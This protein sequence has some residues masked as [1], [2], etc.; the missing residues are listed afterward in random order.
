MSGR[1]LRLRLRCCA[2]ADVGAVRVL[3]VPTGMKTL[4]VLRVGEAEA[5]AES[6]VQAAAH[7]REA[8]G[9]DM[10]V[11]LT[12]GWEFD[13]YEVDEDPPMRDH[14]PA[15]FGDIL[16]QRVALPGRVVAVEEDLTINSDGSVRVDR[17]WAHPADAAERPLPVCPECDG[18]GE[19]HDAF[20]SYPCPKCATVPA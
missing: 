19:V 5:S 9:V 8:T 12:A 15:R 2:G 13:L 20:K 3:K 18:T 11:V 6:T 10:V 1:E 16:L 7:L 4:G 17:G 14:R